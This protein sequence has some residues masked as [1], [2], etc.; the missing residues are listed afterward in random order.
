MRDSINN[1]KDAYL[2]F[3]FSIRTIKSKEKL[4]ARNTRVDKR[5]YAFVGKM[6]AFVIKR[7]ICLDIFTIS[8]RKW[9][10]K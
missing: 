7:K 9:I 3:C 5:L 8:Y 1:P 6:F 10:N 2:M 4:S